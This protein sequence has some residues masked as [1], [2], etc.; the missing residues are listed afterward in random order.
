V[1]PIGAT[2]KDNDSRGFINP[3]FPTSGACLACHATVDAASHALVNTT[4]LG[5]SCFVCHGPNG[6]YSVAKVHASN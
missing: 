6:D 3:V 5:E 2:A 4:S 1:L